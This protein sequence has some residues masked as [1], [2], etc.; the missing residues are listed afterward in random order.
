[1]RYYNE[2]GEE[3]TIN[4][5]KTYIALFPRDREKDVDVK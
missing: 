4:P 5:G 1:M 3:L 2:A